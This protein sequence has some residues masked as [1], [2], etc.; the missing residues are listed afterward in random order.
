LHAFDGYSVLW[1]DPRWFTLGLKPTYG[2]RRQ[3][4][5]VKEAPRDVVDEGRRTYEA[6]RSRRETALRSGK[7][8]SLS[9]QTIREWAAELRPGAPPGIDPGL[10]E[11][12]TIERSERTRPRP[13][14]PMFGRLVHAVLALAPFDADARLLADLAAT[15][16]RV[17]G[18]PAESIAAAASL[19]GDVLSHDLLA[20][21]R[22]AAGRGMCRRE[23]PVILSLADGSLVEGVVDLAFEENG[24][25][26][27]IDYKTDRELADTAGDRHRR[28]VALYASAVA[29]ATG[30][31]ASGVLIKISG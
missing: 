11:T 19:V 5:I 13:V 3:E 26:T 28:Q 9:I 25:W 31:P 8:P 7:A 20:R 6:W 29:Q 30:Q 27:I 4:L 18:T 12:I 15:E 1:C 23:A 2:V 24:A 17:L 10:V 14:G 22:A 21:A 16:G